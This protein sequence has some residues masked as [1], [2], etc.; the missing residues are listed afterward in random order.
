MKVII[1]ITN[2][3]F[4][5]EIITLKICRLNS[6]KIIDEFSAKNTNLSTLDFTDHENLIN[7][8]VKSNIQRID[9]QDEKEGVLDENKPDNVDGTNLENLKNKI[10]EYD[11]KDKTYYPLKMKRVNL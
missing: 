9:D 2:I 3:D 8:I 7:S 5:N 11:Y 6:H 10:I 4:D 1:K